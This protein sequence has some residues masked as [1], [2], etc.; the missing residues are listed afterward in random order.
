MKIKHFSGYGSVNVTKKS[1]TSFI[2]EFDVK[3]TKLVLVVKGN[4]ERGIVRDDIYD[5]R[6][7][8]FNRFEKNFNGNDYDI[9]MSIQNDYV[10]ENATGVEVAI[11]T[12]IY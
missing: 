10:E 4:H 9:K 3:K 8:I 1:K 7:W 12:F 5:V 2:D 11:Y 6:R